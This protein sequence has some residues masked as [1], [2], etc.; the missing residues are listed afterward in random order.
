MDSRL[1][2]AVAG[3][4]R[5]HHQVVPGDG[6]FQVRLQRPGVADAGGAAVADGLE[7]QAVQIAGEA[8]LV[9]VLGDDAG[10]RRKRRFDGRA[11]G[12]A[13]LGRFLC[14]QPRRQHQA[15]IGRVGA[16]CDGGNHNVAVG[17]FHHRLREFS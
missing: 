1:K 4:H 15:G 13:A 16:A 17:Q 2:V 14:H 12:H 5:R 3:Q 6:L 8:G 11:D 7:A 10:P 9:Q